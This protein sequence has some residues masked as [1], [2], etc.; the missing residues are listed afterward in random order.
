MQLIV[1]GGAYFRGIWGVTKL[2]GTSGL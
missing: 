1:I 2:E